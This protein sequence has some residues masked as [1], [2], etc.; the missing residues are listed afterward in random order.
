MICPILRLK[1]MLA[2]LPITKTNKDKPAN[3]SIISV[4]F[5]SPLSV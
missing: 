2:I 5:H 4:M 1:P 3:V